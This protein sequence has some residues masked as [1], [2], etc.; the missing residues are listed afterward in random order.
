VG[1]RICEG[2][3]G[4]YSLLMGVMLLPPPPLLSPDSPFF[5]NLL[6]SFSFL[7]FLRYEVA[8]FLPET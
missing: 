1:V 6:Q 2:V 3:A 4:R 8:G 5:L 7:S